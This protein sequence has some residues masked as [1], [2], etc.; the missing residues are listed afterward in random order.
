M[1]GHAE[2]D[3]RAHRTASNRLS[4]RG[5]R[6]TGHAGSPRR[7]R[8]G[9]SRVA[10]YLRAAAL[11]LTAMLVVGMALTGSAAAGPLWVVC[12]EGTGLTKYSSNQCTK[13]E[14][15][16]KWQ[17]VGL[18]AGKTDTVTLT[19][20]TLTIKDTKTEASIECTKGSE[21]KGFIEGSAKG[22]ITEAKYK[23]PEKNCRGLKVCKE[24]EV[25]EVAGLNT[26]WKIELTETEKKVL[27][28][29]MAGSSG[30]EPGWKV[31]CKTSLG[32]QTDECESESGKEEQ[33]RLE[34]LVSGSSL[35]VLGTFE[36]AHKAECSLGGKETGVVEGQF[37]L[38]LASGNGLSIG[39]GSGKEEEPTATSLTTTLTGESEESEEIEV[40]EN[41]GIKDHATLSGTNAS[42]AGGTVKYKVYSDK[43]CKTLV[44]EAGEVTVTSGSVPASSEEKLKAG[45][46]Y[47]QASYSGDSK[48]KASTSAC[49][50][51]IVVV[52][53]ETSLSTSLSGEGKSGEEIEV[54][55]ES[56]VNDTAT[57]SGTKSSEATG[58][59][60][61]N[62]YSNNKC[63]ELVAEAGTVSVSEGVVPTSEEVMLPAGTYYWQ[64]SYSGEELNHGSKSACT[65]IE[66]A[67]DP[68][69][70][71][72]L[73]GES[74]SG[75]EIEVHEG[76]SV[77]DNA[78][79]HIKNTSTA[80]GTVKYDVYSEEECKK[81][82]AEA[83]EVTVTSG[84]IP[85]SKKETL[86]LGNYY[87][88]ASYSGDGTHSPATSACGTEIELV[89]DSTSLSTSL[90]GEKKI[91]RRNH[92]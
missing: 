21:V 61:Y 3:L 65:E 92:R 34:N 18:A 12:L 83:G 6:E 31:V 85:E 62:V 24:T 89:R 22:E 57:L 58:T 79:L 90:S 19:A 72:S 33:V 23:E 9:G 60:T 71:T 64:A 2:E 51:E 56:P 81:L 88:Q 40:L 45:T 74:K 82:V 53:V 47:W 78:T 28:K 14:A 46:Y 25:K 49:G 67:T 8:A 36:K 77:G 37:A 27:T 41:A 30:K 26:P 86:A 52:N 44:A 43:E 7:G 55:E 68:S 4:A 75:A 54:H 80:T 84:S 29:I 42:K 50:S 59:V 66:V 32:S 10:R 73:S 16:G 87:W 48:N 69:L 63:T 70:T 35:L 20:L 76:A 91:G 13:A 15:G 17:A 38:L 11:C 39:S 1:S 5:S